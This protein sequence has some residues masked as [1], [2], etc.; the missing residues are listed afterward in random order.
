MSKSER[1]TI[2]SVAYSIAL[3]IAGGGL[4]AT[5]AYLTIIPLSELALYFVAVL[6]PIMAILVGTG[7]VSAGTLNMMRVAVSGR[8]GFGDRV[9]QWVRK[10]EDDP[11]AAPDP[12]AQ[13]AQA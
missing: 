11:N 4:I 3:M 12:W 9:R 13:P 5:V 10:L 1:P 8:D 7:F 6:L 2:D